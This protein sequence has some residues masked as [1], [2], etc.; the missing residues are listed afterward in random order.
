ML[1]H[2]LDKGVDP[3]N[4]HVHHNEVD[5]RGTSTFDW[6]CTTS[7]CRAVAD[8]FGIRIIYSWR[9]G[10]IKREI[11]R[12]NEGLQDVLYEEN[13]ELI[14]LQSRPGNSTR[15]KFPAVAADLRTR[16]CSSVVKIDV[17]SRVITNHPEYQEGRFNI[18]S[19]ER[20][21][22]SANRAKYK[23]L[24]PYRSTSKKRV[25]TQVRPI[26]H[27]SEK[28]VWNIIGYHG[29]QPHPSYELGWGRCSCMTCIF[30]SPNT[31][32]TLFG[33]HPLAVDKIHTIESEIQHTLY[34]GKTIGQK[35]DSGTPWT[36]DP[37]WVQQA[38]GE[39][40]APMKPSR[41]RL[42]AGAFSN[43]KSGSV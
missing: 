19:G 4:I 21:Q 15:R 18:Y 5:G 23:D 38:L 16:W 41:W 43:E 40:T 7:Y 14:R 12:E 25:C 17:L 39:F 26:L 37:Y 28:E 22:E 2:L 31:W 35:V 10:G 42:P 34:H 32:A 20:A 9:E 6:P 24:E 36:V 13:G 1:L 8:H 3:D 27:W 11:Y 30:S 33:F 29:I